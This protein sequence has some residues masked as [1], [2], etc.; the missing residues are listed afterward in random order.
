MI[1]FSAVGATAPSLVEMKKLTTPPQLYDHFEMY[2]IPGVDDI[3]KRIVV[4]HPQQNSCDK[5]DKD[6]VQ[7]QDRGSRRSRDSHI[8]DVDDSDDD[9][10]STQSDDDNVGSDRRCLS[11]S[12]FL[13]FLQIHPQI[14]SSIQ[15]LDYIGPY[16]NKNQGPLLTE[17]P[18]IGRPVRKCDAEVLFGILKHLPNLRKLHLEYIV[19]H[20][21]AKPSETHDMIQ[22]DFVKITLPYCEDPKLANELAL[23]ELLRLFKDIGTLEL[24]CYTGP[25]FE[26]WGAMPMPERLRF[27]ELRLHEFHDIYAVV[28]VMRYTKIMN[29]LRSLTINAVLNSSE[30]QATALVE[31]LG[32]VSDKLEYFRCGIERIFDDDE[33]SYEEAPGKQCFY[34]AR[35]IVSK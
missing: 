27:S 24:D 6:E 7:C 1:D 3:W 28:S 23:L 2:H 13:D 35:L 8:M 19:F 17:M 25:Y 5:D 29:K 33:E 21:R 14:A 30:G 4:R 31:M 11:C 10:V 15:I 18:T 20:P 22:L 9:S 12:C 32:A 34:L 26:D 16:A